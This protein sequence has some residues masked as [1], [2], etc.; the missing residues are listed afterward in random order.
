MHCNNT[1]ASQANDQSACWQVCGQRH[2]FGLD[3]KSMKLMHHVSVD[4]SMSTFV[5]ILCFKF[6]QCLMILDLDTTALKL[7]RIPWVH[8]WGTSGMPMTPVSRECRMR[9]SEVGTKDFESFEDV[10]D[11]QIDYLK[12]WKIFQGVD[13][14]KI[15][16]ASIPVG[17]PT[18]LQMTAIAR[19]S[20]RSQKL[21]QGSRLRTSPA[22]EIRYFWKQKALLDS[23]YLFQHVPTRVAQ[24]ERIGAGH[25][26]PLGLKPCQRWFHTAFTAALFQ[27]VSQC[28][29]QSPF[30]PETC[31][32]DA[33]YC[34]RRKALP[35]RPCRH[36]STTQAQQLN[37]RHMSCHLCHTNRWT[38]GIQTN[39]MD[40]KGMKNPTFYHGQIRLES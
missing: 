16:H 17:I 38:N 29:Q 10:Q 31:P 15:L 2:L 4:M 22:V 1:N 21:A 34:G 39:H 19:H 13:H 11:S 30:A 8:A 5:Y 27:L 23:G 40:P 35:C 9:L 24:G 7:A 18:R 12:T 33:A 3:E 26:R 36:K 6:Q 25:R 32:G 28:L 14:L 20:T 37:H